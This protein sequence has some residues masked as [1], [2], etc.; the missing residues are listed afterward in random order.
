MTS[1]RA[2]L[3]RIV[4]M[5]AAVG[6]LGL[7]LSGCGIVQVDPS[8]Q[9]SGSP[10]NAQGTFNFSADP[11]DIATA[12]V[13]QT[14]NVFDTFTGVVTMFTVN[15]T[16]T[17]LTSANLNDSIHLDAGE[18]FLVVSLTFKNS[19][20]SAT[21]CA[22]A[23]AD[24]CIEYFS[25]LQN[26][27]LRDDQGRDWPTTTGARETCTLDPHTMCSSRDWLALALNGVGPGQSATEQLAFIVPTTGT[28]TLFFAPYRFSDASAGTAGGVSSGLH[29]ATLVE[30]PISL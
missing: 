22:N 26:F 25:P 18:Q 3:P 6:L 5:V 10:E 9:N 16:K 29:Q 27:R 20:A 24:N 21:S 15:S 7:L 23:H 1:L 12:T 13:G 28:L 14:V 4:P 19:S 17:M 8:G 2:R 30:V 11:A